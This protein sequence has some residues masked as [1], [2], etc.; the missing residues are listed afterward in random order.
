MYK[1]IYYDINKR[2]L[3]CQESL[4]TSPASTLLATEVCKNVLTD[5]T[6]V[7]RVDFWGGW[8]KE[9]KINIPFHCHICLNF[10]SGVFFSARVIMLSPSLTTLFCCHYVQI[11]QIIKV[12][13]FSVGRLSL[14][15]VL[16][17]SNI[18]VQKNKKAIIYLAGSNNYVIS[19]V[20][21]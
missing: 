9:R 21:S 12:D 13:H 5:N 3:P 8:G 6:P 15:L 7:L 10:F 17:M 20:L 14:T 16:Q 1:K 4:Q 11:I 18:L 2:A 19:G